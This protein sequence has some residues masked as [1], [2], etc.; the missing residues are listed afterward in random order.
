MT[1]LAVIGTAG[2]VGASTL[3]AL[4][5]AGLRG[6]PGGAPAVRGNGSHGVAERIGD[7]EVAHLD[8]DA[9][10]WDVGTTGPRAVAAVL[11]R[12]AT[13]IV[14]VAPAT[15]AGH[16][17][18]AA[19]VAGAVERFGEGV[20]SRISLV[21]MDVYRSSG[22]RDT[23]AAPAHIAVVRVPFDPAL[24]QPGPVPE[25]DALG[26]SARSGVTAW[27]ALAAGALPEAR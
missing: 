26:T 9:A 23:T 2:G 24:A 18:A 7:D 21:L 5:F 25:L 14:L 13:I 22:R 17:D 19:C 27:L 1:T 11:E 12:Q 4:T 6:R 10:I 8:P 3:A 20:L 15:P 16:A